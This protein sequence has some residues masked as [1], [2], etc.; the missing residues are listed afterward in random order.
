MHYVIILRHSVCRHGD[1]TSCNIVIGTTYTDE[2]YDYVIDIDIYFY[3]F[4]QSVYC[5]VTNPNTYLRLLDVYEHGSRY[6]TPCDSIIY[7]MSQRFRFTC[8]T[9]LIEERCIIC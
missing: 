3:F 2:G 9:N 5:F 7:V 4:F 8:K 6:N 1:H